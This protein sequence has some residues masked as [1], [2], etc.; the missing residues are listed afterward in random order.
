MVPDGFER[1][2]QDEAA[3]RVMDV[4]YQGGSVDIYEMDIRES[5]DQ[6]DTKLGTLTNVSFINALQKMFL[7]SHHFEHFS[8]L[9]LQTYDV[10]AADVMFQFAVMGEIVY[11]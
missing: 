7:D 1:Q 2:S 10:E 11:G 6:R 3:H 8:Q 4:I 5:L 9:R